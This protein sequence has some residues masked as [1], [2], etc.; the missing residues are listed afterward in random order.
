MG[1]RLGARWGLAAAIL[2]LFSPMVL[3]MSMT[4][5]AQ[6]ASR[7]CFA[8]ALLAFASA[9]RDGGARGWI[10][11]GALFGMAF[12]CRPL[13]T[14]FFAVPLVGWTLIQTFRRDPAYRLAISAL[15][16]GSAPL[17]ILFLWHSYAMTGNP[18][19]PAR[20]SDPGNPDVMATS[21][22]QRFGDNFSYN[23]FMLAIWFLGPLGLVLVAAGVL[24]DRLTK[25]LGLAIVSDLCLTLFHDNSGLHVVGP[26]HYSECAVPLTII[27]TH[28]L[29]NLARGARRHLFDARVVTAPTAAALGIGLG[30]FTLVHALALRNQAEM[31][32]D[33]YAAI[34]GAVHE[35]GGQKAFVLAPW[36]YAVTGT[37]TTMRDLG[38][39]VH[40]WRRPRLDLSDDVIFLRDTPEAA[41]LRTRFP[42]RRFFRL[43]R[44]ESFPTLVL[45]PLDGGSPIK[46]PGLPAAEP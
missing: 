3:L 30:I 39:W 43:Q 29:V 16:V 15:I 8:L 21:L 4:I 5:H 37:V 41:A 14:A 46:L 11:T 17:L 26:I 22:W 20:F 25:L 10:L 38:S 44:L 12:V 31:Q 1:R 42:D 18:L 45:V 36:F 7:A 40:D 23:T 32:R 35:T 13:E 24:T 19:L 2:F 9:D 28:G 33:V 6:L 27:A 34:E